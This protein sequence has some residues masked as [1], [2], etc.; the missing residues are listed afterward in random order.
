MIWVRSL[1]TAICASGFA[2]EAQCVALMVRPSVCRRW[3][4]PSPRCSAL[5]SCA[6]TADCTGWRL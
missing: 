1:L 5:R 3:C 6:E 4:R 2:P